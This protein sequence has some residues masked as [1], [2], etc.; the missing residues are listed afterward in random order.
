MEF[1]IWKPPTDILHS[2]E[3][4]FIKL[5]VAGVCPEEVEIAARGNTLRIRGCRRDMSLEEGY[6]YHSLEISYSK[7][8]RVVE[9]PFTIAADKIRWQYREGMLL[10]QL[11]K[12]GAS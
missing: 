11:R 8:E 3:R 5:E 12:E 1:A 6:F 7:F 2:G 4:W 9:L 10:I